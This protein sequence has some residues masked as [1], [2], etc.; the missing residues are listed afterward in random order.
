MFLQV[1]DSKNV[2]I[3][4]WVEQQH[5]ITVI[6]NAVAAKPRM[7]LSWT[8]GNERKNASSSSVTNDTTLFNTT[9]I[10]H[11]VP[12]N[13]QEYIS[14]TA[15]F[16]GHTSGTG[17]NKTVMLNTYVVPTDL[18]IIIN[19]QDS[20]DTVHLTGDDNLVKVTF[21]SFGG[22]PNSSLSCKLSDPNSSMT[23]MNISGIQD[24]TRHGNI[25]NLS[26]S[27][28]FLLR[29]Q[30]TK[31]FC[32]SKLQEVDMET[33]IS[34]KVT[35]PVSEQRFV[36]ELPGITT[37]TSL[38]GSIQWVIIGTAAL[39]MSLIFLSCSMIIKKFKFSRGARLS[40]NV[41]AASDGQANVEMTDLDQP[42]DQSSLEK[43]LHEKKPKSELPDIPTGEQISQHSGSS[44]SNYYSATKDSP[45]R[46]R[47][48]NE[49]DICLVLK[50]KKGRIYDRW[51]GTITV[52]RDVS[53]CGVLTALGDSVVKNKDVHW[54]DFV[55]R[56]LDLPQTDHLVKIEGIGIEK[57]FLY[58]ITEHLV[59]DPLDSLITS[60]SS[61]Q[62]ELSSTMS[63]TEVMKMLAGILEG[64]EVLKSYGFLHPGL[65]TKKILYTKQGQCK[66]YDFCLAEDAPKIIAFKKTQDEVSKSLNLFPP[67]ALF[68]SEYTAESDVWAT[69]IVIW[70]V[71]ADGKPPF[72]VD[73]EIKPGDTIIAPN[74]LWPERFLQLRNFLLFDCWSENCSLRPSIH[75][76][77]ASFKTIFEKLID[78]SFYEIPMAT[79]YTPMVSSCVEEQ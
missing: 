34:R 61:A 13:E 25:F 23:D 3:V 18:S 42:G 70:E 52:S 37:G 64:M 79:L 53:K 54:D 41:G 38:V 48:F 49:K 51:M 12:T 8:I 56:T 6:C 55:K 32:L 45:G 68:R 33:N 36:S 76:L 7:S 35:L 77:R 40:T 72:A 27:F 24:Y 22:R 2:A 20:I 39:L 10:L 46:E 15:N 73:K 5:S 47:M 71:I 31:I 19:G 9:S 26:L 4:Q 14:C 43:K 16:D 28:Q 58:L 62:G 21:R 29:T 78:H 1:I 60:D 50:M 65:S 17:Y 75:Q 69:A 44:E 30:E 67:E 74:L 57:S 66:L 59:C 11:H 63:V